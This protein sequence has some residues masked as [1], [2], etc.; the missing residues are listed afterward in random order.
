M[1]PYGTSWNGEKEHLLR[2]WELEKKTQSHAVEM[3]ENE[4]NIKPILIL[5]KIQNQMKTSDDKK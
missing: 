3:A 5:T 2:E 4:R 1:Q